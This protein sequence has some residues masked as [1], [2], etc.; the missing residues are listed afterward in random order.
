MLC[1]VIG[2]A[3]IFAA[4]GEGVALILIGV[5]SFSGL[6]YYRGEFW[7]GGLSFGRGKVP[8]PKFL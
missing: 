6:A 4:R 5:V 2:V 8:I 3:N 1:N 7:E